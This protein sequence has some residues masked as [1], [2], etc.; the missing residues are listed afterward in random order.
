MQ[1]KIETSM[2][3]QLRLDSGGVDNANAN[4]NN[5]IFTIKETELY[6]LAVIFS[7]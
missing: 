4:S 5:V 6:V 3:E 7:V 1:S 2:D